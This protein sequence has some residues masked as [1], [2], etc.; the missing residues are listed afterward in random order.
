[1][2][3]RF[4]SQLYLLMLHLKSQL[5][6][7]SEFLDSR[8][9]WWPIFSYITLSRALYIYKVDDIS[10]GSCVLKA[11]VGRV[12]VDTI[13]RYGDRHS[14]D[15]ST[16]T[17]P[18]YRPTLGRYIGWD[19]VECRSTWTNKHVGRHLADTSPP[20]SQY[21]T[22][23]RATLSSL[24]QLLLPSSIFPVLLTE[25][26]SG[27]RPF[28][29]FNSD[30]IHVIFPAMFFSSSSLLYMT[31]VTFGCSSIW[32]LLLLKACY[33][34]GAKDDIKG[35]YNCTFFLPHGWVFQF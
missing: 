5:M 22:N 34:R 4:L 16:D 1:M 14:A 31:L 23:T 13:G 3:G 21:F 24:A 28:L 10:N 6:N 12:S 11:S 19:S 29:A 27:R 9:T 30:N 15:I 35:W 8:D 17:R 7:K 2:P 32:G 26:F 20:L 18:I 25:A 33:F